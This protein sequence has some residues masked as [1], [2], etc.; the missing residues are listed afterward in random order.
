MKKITVLG[1]IN[2]DI[3]MKVEEMPLKG[4]TISV[5]DVLHIGG[6]KGAN[7]AV[8]A[9]RAGG[10]TN[11][12]GKV[13]KDE[14]G[15]TL[16]SLLK[17]DNIDISHVK[18][19]EQYATGRAFI[20]VNRN[21]ENS[22]MV[23]SGANMTIEDKDV[24]DAQAVIRESDFVVSQFE[25]PVHAIEEAFK[26]AKEH[27]VCT[28][29]NP[30]PAIAKL[31]SPLLAHTDIII[32]NET[33]AASLTGVIVDSEASMLEA[34][35]RFVEMGVRYVIITLGSKGAFYYSADSEFGFVSAFKVKAVDTTAAGDTFIGALASQLNVV[36]GKI[37]NMEEA[38]LFANKAS[39][40]T[41]QGEGAQPSIPHKQQID[42]VM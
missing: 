9:S 4:E 42:A 15:S 29:L 38:I 34:A 30:A 14:D 6:G 39:S 7:Q 41:V 8:A 16:C 10:K 36:E 37:T 22:I 1:S 23:H 11:F 5:Q 32:P 25:V 21:G 19:D 13:G 18:V 27:H 24:A 26:Y 2:M 3:V 20:M 28:I 35:K 40:I 17:E 31:D 12:I 33:E